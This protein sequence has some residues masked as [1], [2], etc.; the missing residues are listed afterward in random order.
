MKKITIILII[1][2]S[3][4]LLLA[5]DTAIAHKMVYL[6]ISRDGTVPP[7]GT[8]T[9]DASLGTQSLMKVTQ[10]AANCGYFPVLGSG[11]GVIYADIA[12]LYNEVTELH[13]NWSSGEVIRFHIIYDNEPQYKEFYVNHTLGD[14]CFETNS[15][16]ENFIPLAV[17]LSSFTAVYHSDQVELLW[18]TQSETSNAGW[19]VFRS[20]TEVQEEALKVNPELI[21]G[22]GTCTEPQQYSFE[23]TEVETGTTCYYWLESLDYSGSNQTYGPIQLQIPEDGQSDPPPVNIIYGLHAAY[24]NPFNPETTINFVMSEAGNA[25]L[26]IYNIKGQKVI[27]LYDDFVNKVGEPISVHWDGK[28]ANGRD[29]GS[30]IYFYQFRTTGR[31]QVKKMVLVK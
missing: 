3:M 16:P 22:H 7:E 11:Y 20:E 6:Q 23:D 15:S 30:G 14:G 13:H 1:L 26:V 12:Q 19:N 2:A 29:T 28:D 24:P 17:T 8:I 5:L 31:T 4:T 27:S 9:F 25:E 10:E 18:I 21:P